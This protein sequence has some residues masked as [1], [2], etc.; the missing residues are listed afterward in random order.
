MRVQELI[1]GFIDGSVKVE[2]ATAPVFSPRTVIWKKS[3]LG[4]KLNKGNFRKKWP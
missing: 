1:Q 4:Q 2:I 3:L